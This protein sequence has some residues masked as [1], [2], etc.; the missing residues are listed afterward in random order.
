METIIMVGQLLLGLSI[1]VGVHEW[2]H[3]IAAKTFGMRVEK[4]YIGFPPK[5]I[6]RTWG[7]TEYCIGAIPLGGFVKISGMIDESLDTKTLSEEPEEWEFR[8]KPAW[9]RLIVML[10]GIIVNVILGIIVFVAITFINGEEYLPK[11][12]LNKYGIVAE[13]L[14]QELGLQT[15]DKIININGEDYKK[16]GDILGPNVL[17]GTDVYYT[18]L[19]GTETVRVDIP[20]DFIEK[21]SGNKDRSNVMSP[22]HPFKVGEVD[23]KEARDAGL[24]TNDKIIALNGIPTLYWDEFI[25]V[26]APLKDKEFEV[27]VLRDGSEKTL[28]MKTS[29]EG[30]LGFVIDRSEFESGFVTNDLSFGKS[31]SIG[32]GRAFNTVYLNVKGIG[33]MFSGDVSPTKSLSGPIRIATMFGTE[34]DWMRFWTLVGLL[35]MV[36][37]FMNLLPIPALDGGHVVFLSWEII[38][39]RKPGEK[40]LENSQKVG[41]VILLA[42]MAFVIFNDVFQLAFG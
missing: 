28:Q 38:T 5:V 20:N 32:T 19:R 21:L 17:V 13:E 3:L 1:L 24:M 30:R 40:F 6:G 9:Q 33:K 39:G 2:G 18:V 12:A 35:S 11:E 25:S 22:R 23:L 8:A 26:L 31:I 14:G 16:Y 4:F 27:R 42:L 15:G 36:L 37:A 7:G 34:W 10:G 29:E 41:M